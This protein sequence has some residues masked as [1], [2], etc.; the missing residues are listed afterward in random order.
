MP[1]FGPTQTP[2]NLLSSTQMPCRNMVMLSQKVNGIE[3]II[4]IFSC[5]FNEAQFKYTMGEQELLAA[6]EACQFFHDIIHGCDIT[7]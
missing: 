6:F 4:S 3:Q 5:N 7:I 2:T 1:F